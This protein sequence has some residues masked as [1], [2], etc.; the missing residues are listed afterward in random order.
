M[1]GKSFEITIYTKS[2]SKTSFMI[3]NKSKEELHEAYGEI[4]FD[5]EINVSHWTEKGFILIPAKEVS[6]ISIEEIETPI[7]FHEN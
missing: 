4:K 1:V 5:S 3:H 7:T 2:N 6:M